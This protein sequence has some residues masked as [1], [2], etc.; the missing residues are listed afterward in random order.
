MNTLEVRVNE[1]IS[2]SK[3]A[4]KNLQGQDSNSVVSN[5]GSWRV[6]DKHNKNMRV[7]ERISLLKINEKNLRTR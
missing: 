5:N 7:N 2:L 3:I 1:R 6:R 4:K